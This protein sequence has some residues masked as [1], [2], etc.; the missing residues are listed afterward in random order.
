MSISSVSASN[1]FARNMVAILKAGGRLKGTVHSHANYGATSVTWIAVEFP[2]VGERQIPVKHEQDLPLGQE[3]VVEC[4]PHPFKAGRYVF[5]L[6]GVV[7]P[8]EIQ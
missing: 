8:A 6:A 4:I 5:Q 1:D 3:V 2:V 7:P